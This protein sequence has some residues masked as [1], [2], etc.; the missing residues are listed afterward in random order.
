MFRIAAAIAMFAAVLLGGNVAEASDWM[1]RR[2]WFTDLPAPHEPAVG[3]LPAHA[4]PQPRS[5]Y[6]PA[7][8]QRGPGFAV[9]SKLRF[10]FYRLYNGRSYDT[11][12]FREFYFEE[13]P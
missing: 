4:M 1:F 13:S 8:P 10:N 12:V 5:A 9:R 6:R 3:A 11:T 7:I 2:S